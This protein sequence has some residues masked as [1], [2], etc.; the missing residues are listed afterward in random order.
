M[1]DDAT[2]N[3]DGLIGQLWTTFIENYGAAAPFYVLAGIGLIMMVIALP[4]VLRKH[5]DPLDRFSFSDEKLRSDLVR[6]RDD[7]DDGSLKGLAE[8]LEPKDEEEMSETRTLLRSAGYR[9]VSAVRQ[10][11]L[12]RAGLALLLLTIGVVITFLVPK[13]PDLAFSG[14]I[15]GLMTLAGYF[16]Q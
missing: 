15:S 2:Q 5:K 14:I 1:E 13:E 12:A 6:L 4:I 7:T 8:F 10:F 11:Y 9:G 3:A 16:L